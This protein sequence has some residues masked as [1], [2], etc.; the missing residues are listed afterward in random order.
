LNYYGLGGDAGARA[1]GQKDKIFIGM[2]LILIFC[3]SLWF[4]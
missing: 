1:L 3:K 2:M 4:L